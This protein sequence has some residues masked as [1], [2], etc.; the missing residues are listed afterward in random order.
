MALIILFRSQTETKLRYPT[1]TP[2]QHPFLSTQFKATRGVTAT[3]GGIHLAKHVA[4]HFDVMKW[5]HFNPYPFSCISALTK[6][7]HR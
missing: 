6:G 7:G 4:K 5:R 2:L 3:D 1:P